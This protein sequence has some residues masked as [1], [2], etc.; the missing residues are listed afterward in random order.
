MQTTDFVFKNT[1]ASVYVA[2]LP[3]KIGLDVLYPQVR[4]DEITACTNERVKRQK[5]YAW[6]LLAYAVKQSFG[7]DINALSFSK[8]KNGKWTS[9]NF[10]FSLSHSKDVVVVAISGA[11]IGMDVEKIEPEKAEFLQKT[12]T[13][14]ERE[15][16][17]LLVEN[18]DR[19]DYLF[20]RWTQK[21]SC[22]KIVGSGAFRP[23]KIVIG[24]VVES[25]KVKMDGEEYMLSVA[26]ESVARVQYFFD[27][28]LG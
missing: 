15:E 27:V 16:F 21:E 26:M 17:A 20:E 18:N 3:D 6:K 14:K 11:P 13:E 28:G 10:S 22:F 1:T 5:Y 4:Q 8:G 24:G 23:A 12:L 7:W 9:P 25:K 19:I 2:K